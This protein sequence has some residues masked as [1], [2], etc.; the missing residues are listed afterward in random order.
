[1]KSNHLQSS[2]SEKQK[3]SSIINNLLLFEMVG[4]V[5]W[6]RIGPLHYVYVDFTTSKE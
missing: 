2:P 1:M 6:I 4:F 5:V 3:I